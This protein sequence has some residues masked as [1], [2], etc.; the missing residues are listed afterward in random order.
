MLH[1][2]VQSEELLFLGSIDV[3]LTRCCRISGR[4]FLIPVIP[5]LGERWPTKSHVLANMYTKPVYGMCVDLMMGSFGR[6]SLPPSLALPMFPPSASRP[7]LILR[8]TPSC[9][10]HCFVRSEAVKWLHPCNYTT[11]YL[12]FD[13]LGHFLS[14]FLVPPY[15]ETHYYPNRFASVS[16]FH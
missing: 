12:I 11:K 7:Y 9:L 10:D 5:K 1:F 3:V 4:I 14:L 2:K 6:P 15:L 8:P 16:F 13:V